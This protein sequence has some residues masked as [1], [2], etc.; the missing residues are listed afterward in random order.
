MWAPLRD[1][2]GWP[3]AQGQLEVLGEPF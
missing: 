3:Q 2:V 1:G